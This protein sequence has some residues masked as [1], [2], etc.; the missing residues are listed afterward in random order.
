MGPRGARCRSLPGDQQTEPGLHSASFVV[1]RGA[2]R[3]QRCRDRPPLFPAT[4]TVGTHSCQAGCYGKGSEPGGPL[5]RARTPSPG[6][7]RAEEGWA[8]FPL[9][10]GSGKF[11]GDGQCPWR[12]EASALRG[13]ARARGRTGCPEGPRGAP[14]WAGT[15]ACRT[16]GPCAGFPATRA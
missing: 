15:Q 3:P 11:L 4:S 7:P 10:S 1:L 5:G 9:Q 14:S 12:R 6:A 16:R 8:P 13:C 2:S